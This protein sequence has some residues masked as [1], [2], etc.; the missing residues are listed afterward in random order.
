MTT[1]DDTLT[2][3]TDAG[4]LIPEEYRNILLK[5]LPGESLL[6]AHGTK[7]PMSRKQLRM[8]LQ[9]ALVSAGFVNG[10]TGL[11]PVTKT[12]WTNKYLNAEVIAAYVV[13]PDEVAEDAEFDIF[14][15]Y[16]PQIVTAISRTLDAAAVFGTNTPASWPTA[17]VPDAIARAHFVQRGSK[18]ATA[19][20]LA[21]TFSDA[22]SLVEADGYLPTA[23]AAVTNYRGQLRNARDSQGRQLAEVSASEVYGVPVTYPLRGQWPNVQTPGSSNAEAIVGD[24]TEAIVGMRDDFRFKVITEGVIS[25]PL[26]PTKILI[27][28]HQ[29]DSRAL[30]VTFRVGF[31]IANTLTYDNPNNSTRYPFAVVTSPTHA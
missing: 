22:F 17:I 10:D 11:K 31:Q 20:A 16:T 6:L 29:Q 24:W 25:D 26:D 13:I 15:A 18:P 28:L 19:G 1:L 3:R 30:R 7:V 12:A 2:G 5:A 23:V 27:N 8:P 21:G 9:S 4:A 14:D